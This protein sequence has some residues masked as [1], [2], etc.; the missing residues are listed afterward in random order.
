MRTSFIRKILYRIIII[1]LLSF[2]LQ[3]QSYAITK[4]IFEDLGGTIAYGINESGQVVGWSDGQA[5]LWENGSITILGPGYATDINESG[6]IVGSSDEKGVLWEN[7]SIND[8]GTT[9]ADDSPATAIN[10]QTHVVGY[11][12]TTDAGSPY[13]AWLWDSTN[14]LQDID[15]T[16]YSFAFDINDNEIVVGR[17]GSPA[18][19]PAIW[20]N[21]AMTQI[22]TS[23]GQTNAINNFNQVAGFYNDEAFVWENGSMTNLGTL[24]ADISDAKAINDPGQ[25]VGGLYYNMST[26]QQYEHAFLWQDGQMYNLNDLVDVNSDFVFTRA[27]DINNKGQIV[28]FG[29]INGERHAF[30]LTPVPEPLVSCVS[31][32]EE[33]GAALAQAAVN[34]RD[35][36]I[37]IRQGTYDGNFTYNADEFETY[38]LIIKGGYKPKSPRC[39]KR[40]VD[41]ANTL[42]DGEGSG[43]V[44]VLSA[45]SAAADFVVDG[46]T[47]QNG[48]GP[49]TNGTGGLYVGTNNS[50][51][52]TLSN[53]A[54]INNTGGVVCGVYLETPTTVT[55]INNTISDNDGRGVYLYSV[56]T[57]T[58]INNTI[59][60]NTGDGL[61]LEL[62]YSD[63]IV[64]IYNNII[65]QNRLYIDND[66]NDTYIYCP[67][68]LFNN[69]FDQSPTGF[70]I[71]QPVFLIDGSNLNNQNPQFNIDGYH[72]TDISPCIDAGLDAEVYGV[73]DDID[74]DSRPQPEDGDY[75]IGADEFVGVDLDITH[76]TVTKRVN[77]GSNKNIVVISLSVKNMGT[78]DDFC[79]ATVVG[80]QDTDEV[81]NKNESVSDAIGK[82]ST[83]F[84][85][86]SF[87]PTL[88]DDI[89]WTVT[90]A[91]ENPDVDVAVANTIVNQ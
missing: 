52:L 65:W 30:L 38:N 32:E 66:P 31:T 60:N 50:G 34:G 55:M 85:F 68:D 82:G 28:G 49:A 54:I 6:Q 90:V 77:L 83:T 24:G 80:M 11:Q 53:S 62:P 79:D 9:G 59:S 47:L 75:D 86:P 46:L 18:H 3:T 23:P 26:P 42:L 48:H 84:D 21:G 70:F 91:D 51:T 73:Y 87:T 4:Y 25:V 72:L 14:G 39:K 13:H 5:V 61:R 71:K 76:F 81:Y 37:K 43:T 22:G 29:E 64:D 7:G 44:L 27:F 56:L 41:P 58:L 19:Y 12:H 89:V 33:L 45:P 2:F 74:G 88:A 57:A 15:T 78:L 10:N 35:D 16:G 20:Q 17:F 63:A 36:I 67:V 69:N 1:F 8:L 40:K